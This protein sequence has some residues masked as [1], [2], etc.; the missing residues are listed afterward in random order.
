MSSPSSSSYIN[1][2]LLVVVAK[3]PYSP[4][5]A[6]GLASL[7]REAVVS[8]ALRSSDLDAS[9]RRALVTFIEAVASA[10]DEEAAAPAPAPAENGDAAAAWTPTKDE[11]EREKDADM[12]VD[13][14]GTG[15]G[16]QEVET[17]KGLPPLLD[18]AMRKGLR[19]VYAQF[20]P[21][22]NEEAG[23]AS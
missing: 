23:E 12:E 20:L 6:R 19:L 10:S 13:G 18:A 16:Q 9:H 21:G 1:A 22:A 4:V 7:L 8:K 5:F 15:N 17:R 3:P 2:G 11:K 14:N